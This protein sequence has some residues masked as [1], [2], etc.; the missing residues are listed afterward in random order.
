MAM[1]C[2]QVTPTNTTCTE[3]VS[4]DI[5]RPSGAPP[6][7]E[8]ALRH[9]LQSLETPAPLIPYHSLQIV[10]LPHHHHH[11]SVVVS[12]AGPV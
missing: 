2:K 1:F 7:Y 8:E 6:T 4:M 12:T 3:H 10:S 11:R 5:Q 9:S